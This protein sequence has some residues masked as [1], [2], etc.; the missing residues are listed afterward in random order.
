MNK[1][2]QFGGGMEFSNLWMMV[3]FLVVVFVSGLLAGLIYYDM[4]VM[5]SAIQT[6]NFQIP[7][8][9]NSTIT[10][11][12][13]TDFQDIMAITV[14]PILGLRTSLPSLVYFLIFGFIIALGMTA[15]MSS[16][17]P[18]FFVV[19]ILFLSLMTY[20]SIIL[21]NTYADLLTNSFINSMMIPFTIYNKIM[22]YLPGIIFFTGL[23]F[24][25]IAFVN[26]IKP[27]N[28]QQGSATGLQYGG[29]Y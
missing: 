15:Y 7:I 23:L 24:A 25:V 21:S 22:L 6:I 14:Y 9:D 27:T 20:F 4:Q 1:K 26:L 17:N 13:I 16:K 2:G 12:S 10:N 28:N 19:H 3:V 11:S 18:I 8:Q 5:D 29:D